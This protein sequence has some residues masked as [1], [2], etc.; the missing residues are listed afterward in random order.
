[1][2]LSTTPEPVPFVIDKH[3]TAR[4]GGTR[5][6]LDTVVIEYKKGAAP[7]DIVRGFP[8]ITLAEVYSVIAYYL[9][10]KTEVDE[11]LEEGFEQSEK[12]RAIMEA[13]HGTEAQALARLRARAR[14][15]C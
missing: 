5:L 8:P 14:D 12:I 2:P 13:K 4:V 1:M 3:G 15:Q 11:Y 6:T 10:W 7:E 9:R